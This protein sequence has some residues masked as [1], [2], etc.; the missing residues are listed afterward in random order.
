MLATAERGSGHPV[1]LLHGQPGSG[2]SWDPVTRLLEPEFRVLAPDRPGYGATTAEARGIAA[3]AAA[4]GDFLLER[5][6]SPATV[7]AH[8]WAGGVAVLLA[9]GRPELVADLVLV[10]AACT[11]D[12]VDAVDRL[13]GVPVLGG[14]LTVAGLV[15]IGEVLPRL[16]PLSRYAPARLRA[17]LATALPDRSV[18]GGRWRA[19]GRTRRSF[20]VEQHALLD[21]L[22]A[23]R[24]AL[25]SVAVPTTVVTG[26]WDLVVRPGAAVTLADAIP[27]ATLV[28]VPDAGH[29]VARDAP[30][31]LAEVI[32]TGAA[33]TAG[34]ST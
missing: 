2:A 4:L 8:S 27:G 3:N 13:L 12:S 16:R 17:P 5:G 32:R 6:A 24:A 1:V 30:E 33:A 11:E 21:E 9:T 25:P 31:L 34:P 19:L 15:A 29:F 14:L 18:F 10:G 20:L 22:D 23:V 28:R 26:E 7:V